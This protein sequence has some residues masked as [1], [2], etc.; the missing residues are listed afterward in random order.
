MNI[1]LEKYF[2]KDITVFI[3]SK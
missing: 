3:V 2:D 1:N